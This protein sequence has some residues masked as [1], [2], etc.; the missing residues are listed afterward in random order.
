VYRIFGKRILD[1][2][3]ALSGLIVLSPIFLIV[4]VLVKLD[5]SGPVFFRQRRI[6]REMKYFNL[7]KFRSMTYDKNMQKDNFEPGSFLRVTRV[8]KFLRKAKLDEVPQL[9]NVL[10]GEMS[11]VGPRPEVERYRD[12][13]IGELSDVLSVRPGITDMASI[14]YRN[15][16]ELLANSSNPERIYREV[17]L[18]DKLA[19]ALD[20]VQNKIK[21]HID[22]MIIVKTIFSLFKSK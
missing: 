18:P 19:I 20:Y 13:Y 12:L 1:F 21:F 9:I 15:E 7:L 14:K 17:I 16:Q 11:F 10:L 4:P 22:I 2:L 5:S 6:G 8:G 3:F